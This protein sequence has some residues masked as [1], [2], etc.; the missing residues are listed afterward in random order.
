VQA[1]V[2]FRRG[3]DRLARAADQFT[4]AL[5]CGEADPLDCHR[6]LMIAPALVERGLAVAHL[7]KDGSLETQSEMEARLLALTG[8]DT[9]LADGLF[10]ALLGAEERRYLLAAA[11]RARARRIAFRL[12]PGGASP[13]VTQ[14]GEGDDSP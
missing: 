7:R 12:R 3:L 8:T 1:T 14:D 6:G 4:V 11:Y 10:A 5:L 9:G 2:V 13:I